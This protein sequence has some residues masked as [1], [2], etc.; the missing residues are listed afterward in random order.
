MQPRWF[1]QLPVRNLRH[2]RLVP[3]VGPC[4]REG[5]PT[6]AKEY[7]VL[8][9]L[10]GPRQENHSGT[11]LN[12]MSMQ[13]V[14][15]VLSALLLTY[16]GQ[17]C[18]E[19]QAESSRVPSA[20][21]LTVIEDIEREARRLGRAEPLDTSRLTIVI[22]T[23]GLV[24]GLTYVWG[25]YSYVDAP[26]RRVAG[27][28]AGTVA[29]IRE[30]R[31]WWSVLG[32][33]RPADEQAAR[34]ACLEAIRVTQDGWIRPRS[35]YFHPDSLQES[36]FDDRER[37]LLEARVRELPTVRRATDGAQWTVTGWVIRPTMS[38]I[39]TQYRCSLPAQSDGALP[40]LVALDSIRPGDK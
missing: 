11:R 27:S 1:L 4:S 3:R 28:R 35:V 8:A 20:Q 22:D 2:A 33:W 24:P 37:A 32:T 31:D 39:A 34:Q 12:P 40:E 15:A 17:G 26:I 21:T 16:V 25:E 18:A 5:Y 30:M 6:E 23:S 29:I 36:A 38:R 10:A 7:A 14:A 19:R 9:P 13:R